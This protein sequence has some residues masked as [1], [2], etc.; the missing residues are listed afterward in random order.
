M[1]WQAARLRQVTQE[2]LQHKFP[3]SLEEDADR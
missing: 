1:N 3:E 2:I